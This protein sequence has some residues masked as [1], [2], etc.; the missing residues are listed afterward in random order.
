V[1]DSEADPGLASLK[2]RRKERA[3]TVQKAGRRSSQGKDH[4]ELGK[5]VGICSE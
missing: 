2:D 3:G 4:E 1:E 5:V